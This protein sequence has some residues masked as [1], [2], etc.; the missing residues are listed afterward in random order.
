MKKIEVASFINKMDDET[1]NSLLK[2]VENGTTRV[3][4][5]DSDELNQMHQKARFYNAFKMN[6]KNEDELNPEIHFYEQMSKR[7]KLLRE[8][9]LLDQ[10]NHAKKVLKVYRS[11]SQFIKAHK[12]VQTINALYSDLQKLS[13]V[14]TFSDVYSEDGIDSFVDT[15]KTIEYKNR[16]R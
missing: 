7:E 1:L 6:P 13:E 15:I 9:A 12:L 16:A 4:V 11:Y 14:Q 2:G 10:I 5:G 8:K 3:F